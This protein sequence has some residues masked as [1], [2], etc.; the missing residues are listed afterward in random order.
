MGH[1]SHYFQLFPIILIISKPENLNF[2]AIA[3]GPGL[4]Q[5]LHHQHTFVCNYCSHLSAIIP[6]A[7]PAPPL[8]S[9]L[10][11]A[12]RPTCIQLCTA[13][14]HASVSRPL[15]G[16]IST[17]HSTD[18][19]SHHD[20]PTATLTRGVHSARPAADCAQLCCPHLP[21]AHHNR[22]SCRGAQCNADGESHGDRPAPA[23]ALRAG[24]SPRRTVT[25]RGRISLVGGDTVEVV[26]RTP[27]LA[28]PD[29]TNIPFPSRLFPFPPTHHSHRHSTSSLLFSSPP[30]PPP[31]SLLS[32]CP[33]SSASPPQRPSNARSSPLETHS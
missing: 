28:P 13:R 3:G 23:T 6:H 32:L 8:S 17:L 30:F 2:L 26:A 14:L 25:R 5:R 31:P 12:Q 7:V 29:P 18:G 21:R 20:R 10:G 1:Q 4:Y 27:M 22:V 16:T 15:H 33:V 19:E 9:A 11:C 24:H